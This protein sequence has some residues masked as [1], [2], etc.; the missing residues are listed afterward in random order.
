MIFFIT[1]SMVQLNITLNN[2][3]IKVKVNNSEQSGGGISYVTTPDMQYFKGSLP[4]TFIV[5]LRG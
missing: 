5:P 2:K 1:F 4:P 3:I